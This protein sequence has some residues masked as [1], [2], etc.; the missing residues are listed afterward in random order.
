MRIRNLVAE[1]WPL[2]DALKARLVRQRL[3]EV[4][5]LDT[6]VRSAIGAGVP[7]LVGR[8][9]GTEARVLGAWFKMRYGSRLEQIDARFW[10]GPYGRRAAQLRDLSGVYPASRA[11]VEVFAME[12]LRNFATLDVLGVWGKTF[13]WIE[14]EI[15]KQYSPAIT[16][17]EAV[18]PWVESWNSLLDLP[19][20]EPWSACLDGRRVLLVSPFAVEMVDQWKRATSLFPG[21]SLPRMELIPQVSPM[22]LGGL[23]D[24][25]NW[26]SH[27]Q[28]QA[29]RMTQV[30]FDVALIG[31]G[32]YSL[33]L[34]ATAKRLG[35]VGVHSGG[36]LQ[37]F[38]GILGN[39]WNNNPNV[40]RFVNEAWIR[41]PASSRP[42]NWRSVEG[43]CYW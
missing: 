43:G 4:Q 25:R 36:G 38:F 29:D 32:A 5:C 9:G 37:L 31:A 7:A 17:I 27:L 8:V 14:C 15:I 35:A 3:A 21:Y 1:S 24:G 22:T 41:P 2:S 34:A 18:A 12:Y 33:P 6:P 23:P 11:M 13:T 42:A 19:P 28:E 10:W 39:R 30:Q 20:A 40:R 16:H 26:H